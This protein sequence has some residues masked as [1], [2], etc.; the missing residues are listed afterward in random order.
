MDR[1]M[2]LDNEVLIK[3]RFKSAGDVWFHTQEGRFAIKLEPTCFYVSFQGYLV[4]C[5]YS[6]V[7]GALEKQFYD[8]LD[9]LFLMLTEGI[10]TILLFLKDHFVW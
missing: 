10:R 8:R 4:K 6:R 5:P 3:L 1:T 2:P 9:K 7:I